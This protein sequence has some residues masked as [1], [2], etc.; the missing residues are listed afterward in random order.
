MLLIYQIN[1]YRNGAHVHIERS[2]CEDFSNH[3]IASTLIVVEDLYCLTKH[4][5]QIAFIGLQCRVKFLCG[6]SYA[7]V[8]INHRTALV[9]LVPPFSC[10]NYGLRSDQMP[11][12]SR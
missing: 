8:V 11:T 4:L 12:T 6:F 2:E 3:L 10:S 5:A 1:R 9:G 7:N